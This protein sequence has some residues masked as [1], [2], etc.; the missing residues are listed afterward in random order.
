MSLTNGFLPVTL[1]VLVGV[2]LL[3]V[4]GWRS[5]RWRLL[6]VP[7][8]VLTGGALAALVHWYIGYQGWSQDRPPRSSG[9]GSGWP[10]W[11]PS[12]SIAGWRGIGW[13]RRGASVSAIALCLLCAAVALNIWVGYLPTVKSAWDLAI[14]T[15]SPRWVDQ[16]ALAQMQ[17]DGI[18]PTQ[19]VVVKVTT[20]DAASGFPHRQE[21]VYLPPAWFATTPPPRLPAVMMFSGEFGHPDNW[22]QSAHALETLDKFSATH[23]GNAPV[24][25][26]PDTWG[27][28]NN[29]TECVN[30]TR[31]NAADHLTKDVLPFVISNFG[32]SPDPAN[33]GLAGWSSGGTCA[34]ML[35]VLHPELFS[36][37]VDIDGQL[38]PTPERASRPSHG[39]SAVTKPP[40]QRSTPRL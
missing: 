11:P 1:Q 40:G 29:D 4:I 15:E 23:H 28:F 18:R 21:L 38:G 6:W 26:F 22:L 13:W 35:A 19:G 25:V 10:A 16:S 20:P 37:I 36:A 33:W 5:R 31:G 2:A 39:C 14:G 30:G 24:M 9:C 7:V 12:S 34:L 27:D 17:R 3:A 8:A 32:V